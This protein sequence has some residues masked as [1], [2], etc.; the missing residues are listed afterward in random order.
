MTLFKQIKKSAKQALK[1]AWG[2]AIILMLIPIA[3]TML[4]DSFE[5]ALRKIAGVPEFIDYIATPNF[6]LDDLANLSP[7]SF[8]ISLLVGVLLFCLSVPLTQGILRWFFRRTSG[9]DDSVSEIF[10]YFESVGGFLKTLWLHFQIELRMLLWA[11]LLLV[12]FTAVGTAFFLMTPDWNASQQWGIILLLIAWLILMGIF[13]SLIGL[14]YFL[15]P[16][17]LARDPS[18]K[19]G[20]IIRQ[21][22]KLMRGHKG[23]L[24]L[25]QL[26]FI[27]WFLPSVAAVLI[28]LPMAVS[29][30]SQILALM[31]LMLLLI[32]IQL[33]LMFYLIPYMSMSYSIYARYLIERGEGDL[34][35]ITEQNITREYKPDIDR[36]MEEQG[37]LGANADEEQTSTDEKPDEQPS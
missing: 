4:V 13:M 30:L 1:G 34:F 29:D 21:S 26:S 28:I 37:S 25:F 17:L 6:A 35:E 23:R 14:R 8:L 31:G 27:L 19:A 36:Y 33:A 9:E 7:V 20:Q 24:L 3:T 22:V 18:P 32:L 16:Y 5:F 12:P 2:R 11:L 15:A 10:H